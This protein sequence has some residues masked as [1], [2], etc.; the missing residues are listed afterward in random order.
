MW[1]I[2]KLFL[3]LP[4]QRGNICLP[5]QHCNLGSSPYILYYTAN[6]RPKR[7]KQ[8]QELASDLDHVTQAGRC[9]TTAPSNSAC[10]NVTLSSVVMYFGGMPAISLKAAEPPLLLLLMNL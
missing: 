9:I 4:R 2:V 10:S 5:E 8:P 1:K 3:A 7:L 6:T